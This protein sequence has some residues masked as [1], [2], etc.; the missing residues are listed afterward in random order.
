MSNSINI[1]ETEFE[2][3]V[4]GSDFI[5]LRSE[6]SELVFAVGEAIHNQNYACFEEVIATEI[7]IC[8]KLS[9]E[10]ATSDLEKLTTLTISNTDQGRIYEIPV[11]FTDHEDWLLI[12]GHLGL[13]KQDIITRLL[14][15][16]IS[17]AMFGFLPGFVYLDGLP[18]NLHVPRKLKP[19]TKVKK[20][21][22]A[23]GGPYL[24]IYSHSS[25]GGWNAIGEVGCHIFDKDQSPPMMITQGDR[26]KLSQLGQQ[27]FEELQLQNT[28][29]LEFNEVD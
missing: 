22:L 19:S 14:D 1:C 25:P 21:T 29:I 26:F 16:D 3:N 13:A 2:V 9:S 23:I 20:N 6:D 15:V 24:G 11:Y 12:E 17:V 4:F 7:E 18:T 8:L 28:S 10:F 5:L 27:Q